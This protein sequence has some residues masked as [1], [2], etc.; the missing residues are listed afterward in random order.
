MAID[1]AKSSNIDVPIGAVIIKDNELI[2]T[3]INQIEKE[4][5]C[6]LHAEIIAI[7][8]ASKTLNDW[9]LNDCTLYSTLEPC[10]MCTGAIVN[11]RIKKVV[12]GAFDFV[13]GACG[14]K[15]NL[16]NDLEKNDIEIIS[17]ILELECVTLLKDFF[18]KA[19]T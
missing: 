12:F 18:K 11:S 10:S 17:G 13:Q 2:S 14:S 3:G 7:R 4:K 19:R 6:T 8:S 9:R 16:L 1:L 5:D 15:A